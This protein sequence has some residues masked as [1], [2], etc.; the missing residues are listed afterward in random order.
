MKPRKRAELLCFALLL[1]C[2]RTSLC[3]TDKRFFF[4]PALPSAT[5]LP[6]QRRSFCE[7]F[8]FLHSKEG[9]CYSSFAFSR[10]HVCI[11]VS[12][13][14]RARRTKW[15][16]RSIHKTLSSQSGNAARR[17]FHCFLCVRRSFRF[18]LWLSQTH[19]L[20]FLLFVPTHFVFVN[21]ERWRLWQRTAFALHR[22]TKALRTSSATTAHT[23]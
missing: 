22:V 3:P 8:F 20:V 5:A 10:V 6:F 23:G 7:S 4:P 19:N 14:S 11:C 21:L 9:P 18:P 1:L 12:C 13:T 16:C 17:G 2:D 15:S